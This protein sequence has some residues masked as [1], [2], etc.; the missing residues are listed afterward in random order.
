MN[1]QEYL[2]KVLRLFEDS[3]DI[4]Q[5]H[6]PLRVYDSLSPSHLKTINTIIE[7]SGGAIE[8]YKLGF[9]NYEM[10]WSALMTVALVAFDLGRDSK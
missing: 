7:T 4:M 1:E 5:A 6:D 3:V 10:V 8:A 2:E 9:V